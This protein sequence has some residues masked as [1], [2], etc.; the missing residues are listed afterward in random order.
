MPVERV[1]EW[2]LCGPFGM[3]TEG[4]Q[5]LLEEMRSRGVEPDER[6]QEALDRS[7]ERL[8]QMGTT[9]IKRQLEAGEHEGISHYLSPI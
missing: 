6:T 5:A 7:A 8:S 1:D 4:R 3:V 9:Q 2:Y